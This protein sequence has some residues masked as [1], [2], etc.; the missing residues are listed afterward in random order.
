MKPAAFEYHRPDS[1]T[2]ALALL[3]RL[4]E[5]AKALAGGQSLVPMMNLRIARPEHLVDLNAIA[6]LDAIVETSTH[7]EIG[8]MARQHDIA[9][10][11]IVRRTCPL[12]AAAAGTIGH[13][14]IRRRGTLG[15]S[16]AHADPA[17]Q[18]PLVA[19][20]TDA[21][22][23]I[24]GPRG[25]RSVAAA[26]FFE[27]LM[28]TALGADELIVKARFRRLRDGERPGFALFSQRRGD[29]ALAAACVT[30]GARAGRIESIA[31]AV[32]GA[33]PVPARLDAAVGA[34]RGAPVDGT[35]AA[36]LG[37]L[38]AAAVE[39]DDH[40]RIPRTFRR[41]LVGVVTQRAALIAMAADAKT[42][43][44]PGRPWGG[45]P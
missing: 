17:A 22:I 25:S 35:A 14:A 27:G 20:A 30:L 21:Q 37:A 3:A 43:A 39:P 13:Y 5:S 33:T 45:V 34:V 23:E 42:P 40:P 41:E 10:S 6:G 18:L 31:V 7:V 8:A 12:L 15:G 4:K 1:L 11:A 44:M 24:A 19:I 16:L 36:R 28:T 38:A 9:E 29:F 32:G 2:E 26:T